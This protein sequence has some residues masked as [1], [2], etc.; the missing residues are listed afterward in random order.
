[1]FKDPADGSDVAFSA[2]EV[3]AFIAWLRRQPGCEI[4]VRVEILA[5]REATG[6][7]PPQVSDGQTV[8]KK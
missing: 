5:E 6:D 4:P 2:R 8:R 1:M 3:R 7:S